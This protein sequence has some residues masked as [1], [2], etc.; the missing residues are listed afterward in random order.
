D[1]DLAKKT[2]HSTS[3]QAAEIAKLAAVDK[4]LIGHFSTRYKDDV[5]L[6]EEAKLIFKNTEAVNDGDR[7]EIEEKR[8][9]R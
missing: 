3:R 4:L 2:L 6:L 1:K 7:F 8:V 9:I 5:A